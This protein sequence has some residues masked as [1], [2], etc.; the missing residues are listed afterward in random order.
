M[1]ENAAAAGLPSCA[2]GLAAQAKGPY[3]REQGTRF[4]G[5]GSGLGLQVQGEGQCEGS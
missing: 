5:M 4:H 1:G 3:P 2:R